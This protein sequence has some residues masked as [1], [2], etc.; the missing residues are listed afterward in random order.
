MKNNLLDP[1]VRVALAV[2]SEPHDPDVDEYEIT[3]TKVSAPSLSCCART[4]IYLGDES[5]VLK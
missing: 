5:S 4:N 3:P 2:A 1:I